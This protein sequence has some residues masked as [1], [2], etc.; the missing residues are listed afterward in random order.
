[1]Q[2][3]K[4][5]LIKIAYD[6]T[7]YYGF[8]R[9]KSLPTIEGKLERAL[10][11]L[12]DDEIHI[13]GASR[14][15]AGVHALGNVAIFDTFSSIPAE[16]FPFALIKY[17]PEDIRVTGSREVDIAFNPRK[18]ALS[19]VYEYTY[20]CGPIEDPIT[21]RFASFE[22]V[23]PDVERM[24]EAARFLIGEHDFT[25]FS[26]P[27]SQTLRNGG[28][29][30]RKIYSIDILR[31]PGGAGTLVRIKIEGDGFLYHMV[32]IITGTLMNVGRGLWTPERVNEALLSSTRSAAGPT[33]GARGLMLKSI[34]FS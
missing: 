3:K 9:Q 6:G 33:A 2:S 1:M 10:S 18:M 4:R 24:R 32:R 27:A 11:E 25:S 23:V 13:L 29:A 20:S 7:D 31:Q 19:K 17:L 21:R 12:V 5:I 15:D 8:E 22:R 28:S 16:R 34:R 26:N 14:T 30:V